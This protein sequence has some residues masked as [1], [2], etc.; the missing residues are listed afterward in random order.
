M[1]HEKVITDL[2]KKYYD[3][4]EIQAD[5]KK[6]LKYGESHHRMF[7]AS[8]LKDEIESLPPITQENY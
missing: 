8:I 4:P 2:L 6:M 3:R 1:S 5:L 7:V